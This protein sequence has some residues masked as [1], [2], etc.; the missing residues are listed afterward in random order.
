MGIMLKRLFEKTD[1]EIGS[2]R[3][4]TAA[5]E[6][7][8]KQHA[9]DVNE[10]KNWVT[11]KL[12]TWEKS[13]KDKTDMLDKLRVETDDA[14]KRLEALIHIVQR[15]C[16]ILKVDFRQSL[17]DQGSALQNRVKSQ[18]ATIHAEL[19]YQKN[20]L[21]RQKTARDTDYEHFISLLELQS[22]TAHSRQNKYIQEED[23]PV[24]D[25]VAKKVEDL[26]LQ[27]EAEVATRAVKMDMAKAMRQTIHV[28]FT[29]RTC[30][31]EKA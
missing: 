26:A 13:K 1:A 4:E 22:N 16:E 2:L 25:L 7:H 28:P 24:M 21:E 23:P 3:V 30:S 29:S 20:A 15:D 17:Q 31:Q 18:I 9:A 12:D 11:L 5:L 6:K 10:L 14:Q 8:S 19:K 27:L